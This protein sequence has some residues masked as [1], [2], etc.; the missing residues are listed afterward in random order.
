MALAIFDLDHTLLSD[1]SDN[2]WGQFLVDEGV[3][4]A[5]TYKARNDEFYEH[6]KQGTLDI[7]AY[8]A[9]VLK[10]LTEH[11]LEHMLA[12]RARFVKQ[13]I[14]PVI[15]PQAPALIQRHKDAGDTLLIITA[16]NE[17]I[18]APIAE[19]LGIEHLIAPIPEC[20][21]G[22]YT[23]HIVGEPSFQGGKI[24]RLEQWLEQRPEPQ[25]TFSERYFYSDS[26]NDLPLLKQVEHPIAVDPDDTL[27]QHAK[28]AGWPVISLR[29]NA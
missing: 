27:H 6:Y 23:G 13:R 4:D 29:G 25:D 3:V 8:L 17:F 9:F 22:R 14:E 24:V 26:H 21:D 28:Q 18:T 19:R 15:A 2:L 16:T 7:H 11:P 5:T 10:P 12:L 20:I 1:D